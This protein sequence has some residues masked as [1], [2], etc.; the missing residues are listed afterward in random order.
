MATSGTTLALEQRRGK[1]LPFAHALRDDRPARAPCGGCQ[2]S[3]T[4]IS[5][6]LTSG[7]PPPSSVASVRA[8]CEVA[9]L[10]TRR[11]RCTAASAAARSNRAPLPG[12]L[13]PGVE[14]RRAAAD[15]RRRS[16]SRLARTKSDTATMIARRQR[17]LGVEAAVELGERRHHLDDDDADEHDGQRDQD[18]RVD[19][20]RDRLLADRVDRPSRRRRSGAAPR[21]GCRRA[22]PPSATRC[23][24]SGNSSPCACERVRQRRARPH[25]LVHVVEHRLERPG[26]RAAARRMSSDCTSGM[27]ALSS[28]ASSWLKTRNSCRGDPCACAAAARARRSRRP[29]AR[30]SDRTC[31]PFSSSSRRRCAS[32]SAT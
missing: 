3:A 7:M 26:W 12:L 10:W 29:P 4:A 19:Q 25:L 30:R 28:V 13:D 32:L 11:R 23:R 16:A 8:S 22:R 1:A 18:G 27:P 9:N 21:R 15:D 14:R 20:R 24:R 17:Q 6:A 2:S 31:R 5:S